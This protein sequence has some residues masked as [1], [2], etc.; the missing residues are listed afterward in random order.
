MPYRST[1]NTFVSA[2]LLTDYSTQLSL[3]VPRCLMTI[4]SSRPISWTNS[5]CTARA[6]A[7]SSVDPTFVSISCS[8]SGHMS[9]ACRSYN[10]IAWRVWKTNARTETVRA[11]GPKGSSQRS[12]VCP[13][14]IW[15]DGFLISGKG[16]LKP[17]PVKGW[18]TKTLLHAWFKASWPGYYKTHM[19]RRRPR[20]LFKFKLYMGIY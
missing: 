20:A 4:S 2:T 19:T 17:F 14:T 12:A 10:T 5:K 1:K 15:E 9:L 18:V 8:F 16:L 13:P 3:F 11:C 6:S 7:H